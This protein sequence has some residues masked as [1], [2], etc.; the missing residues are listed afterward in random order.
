MGSQG[1]AG[2]GARRSGNTV[3]LRNSARGAYGLNEKPQC[4]RP[5][6]PWLWP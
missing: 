5:R 1:R 2:Q 3:I 4:V 6:R